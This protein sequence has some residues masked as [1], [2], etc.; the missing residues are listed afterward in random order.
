LH[1]EFK[2]FRPKL[3]VSVKKSNPS[4][5]PMAK[6]SSNS[7]SSMTII[8]ERLNQG[9]IC[10]RPKL[11]RTTLY[12]GCVGAVPFL[13]S[14]NLIVCRR[15]QEVLVILSGVR[16]DSIL[17]IFE[18]DGDWNESWVLSRDCIIIKE[19]IRVKENSSIKIGSIGVMVLDGQGG[20]TP[21]LIWFGSPEPNVRGEVGD[22]I[23]RENGRL[24]IN[25]PVPADCMKP[26]LVMFHGE[27]E[28]YQLVDVGSKVCVW[29]WSRIVG[30]DDR[31]K[32]GAALT[33]LEKK[34]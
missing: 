8:D 16:A 34:H 7:S 30:S 20:P 12:P 2:S 33:V 22:L 11:I 1:P 13:S 25:L 3:S 6:N 29:A 28:K 21:N 32:E 31:F 15:T 4:T 5:F 10:I 19:G 27:L 14:N 17:I 23:R 24:I 9:V 18:V 26:N